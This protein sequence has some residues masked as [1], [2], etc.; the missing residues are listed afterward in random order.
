MI[1]TSSLT[2]EYPVRDEE[3]EIKGTF[4]AIDGVEINA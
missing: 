3:G 2:Y 1:K 4:R